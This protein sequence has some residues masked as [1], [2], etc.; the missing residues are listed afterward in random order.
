IHQLTGLL[1]EEID[2]GD[3]NVRQVVSG[4]AKFFSP[5]ELVNRHVVLITNVK[6]GKLRDVMSAGLGLVCFK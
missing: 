2:L 4:L 5:D 3:G 6:P 1:V